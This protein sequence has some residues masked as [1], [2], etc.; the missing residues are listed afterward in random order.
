[1]NIP[2]LN[3]YYLLCYAWKTLEEKEGVDV[4]AIDSTKFI[5]LLAKVLITR[6]TELLKRGLDR[7]YV[8]HESVVNGIKGKLDLSKSI[9][10]NHLLLNKTVC[11]YDEFDYDIL[12]NQILRTTIGKLIKV[13]ELDKDHKLKLHKLS[14]KL[15]FVSEVRIRGSDFKRIRLQGN[16]NHYKLILHVCELINNNALIEKSDGTYKFNDFSGD[17]GAMRKL[18]ET[19]IR[20]FYKKEQ[21]EYKVGI[22]HINWNFSPENETDKQF[23]PTMITDISLT[24]T[25]RKIIIDTKYTSDAFKKTPYGEHEKISSPNLYQ[26][27]SYLLNQEDGSRTAEYCEGILLYPTVDHDFAHSYRYN[28]HRISVRSI[29]LNQDWRKI[30][31]DL[32]NMISTLPPIKAS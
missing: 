5:D 18:F 31:G 20:N 3:I 4:R 14:N 29:N 15:S 19:F 32:L 7:G 25:H 23:V 22:E 10:G 1:M 16:N 27:F 11:S 30:E 2:I 28:N 17:E 24:S 6:T 21:S 9:K 13:K 8:E 12:H 26:L